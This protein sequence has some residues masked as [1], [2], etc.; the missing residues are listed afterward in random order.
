MDRDDIRRRMGKMDQ[1][2]LDAVRGRGM[3]RTS[4]GYFH[5]GNSTRLASWLEIRNDYAHILAQPQVVMGDYT[6]V[7]QRGLSYAALAVIAGERTGMSTGIEGY[8]SLT[9]HFIGM[10]QEQQGRR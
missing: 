3:V 10:V 9:A 6:T 7:A 5:I 4:R 8:A 1:N 2:M